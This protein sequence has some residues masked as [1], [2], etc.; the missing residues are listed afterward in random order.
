MLQ[1]GNEN[2][3][4]ECTFFKWDWILFPHNL[5]KNIPLLTWKLMSLV[6]FGFPRNFPSSWYENI[7]FSCTGNPWHK[8]E[9]LLEETWASL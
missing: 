4:L 2:L 7:M 1:F 5:G 9:K 6:S 8:T 3:S